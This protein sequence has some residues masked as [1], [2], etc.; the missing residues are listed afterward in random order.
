MTQNTINQAVQDFDNKPDGA[1]LRPKACAEI[2]AI[3]IS[4][5][6]RLVKAG[7][8]PTQKLTDRITTVRV[9]DLRAFMNDKEGA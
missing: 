3:S 1:M 5:Y 8:I 6:W 9:S 2:L 4:T 7:K